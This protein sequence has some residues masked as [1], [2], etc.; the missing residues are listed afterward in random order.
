MWGCAL[1]IQI[2]SFM[3]FVM[4][5]RQPRF[6]YHGHGQG[7]IHGDVACHVY[8]DGHSG[9]RLVYGPYYLYLHVHDDGTNIASCTM[10]P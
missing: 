2:D 1:R 8:Y 7:S 4:Y 10:Y 3:F 9:A 5:F 6:L